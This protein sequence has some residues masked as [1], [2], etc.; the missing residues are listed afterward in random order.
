MIKSGGIKSEEI[1]H[2]AGD[3]LLAIARKKS[4]RVNA[5]AHLVAS[6]GASRFKLGTREKRSEGNQKRAELVFWVQSAAIGA[7]NR[8][9]N[10]PRRAASKLAHFLDWLNLR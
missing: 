8:G 9:S 2:R 4:A 7:N 3:S 10:A 6:F 1:P 5:S